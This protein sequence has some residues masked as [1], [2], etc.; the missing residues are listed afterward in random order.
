[1]ENIKFDK[2]RIATISNGLLDH[3]RKFEEIMKEDKL[4][5]ELIFDAASM[6]IFQAVNR[7]I[8][9]ADEM[10]IECKLTIPSKYGDSFEVLQKAKIIDDTLSKT[11]IELVYYRNLISHE[12][13]EITKKDLKKIRTMSDHVREFVKK[14]SDYIQKHS[15]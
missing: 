2:A 1:M 5:D 7:S 14:I 13:Y 15:L 11:M 8:D 10:I 9:L 12:Y 4:D 3:V 6:N